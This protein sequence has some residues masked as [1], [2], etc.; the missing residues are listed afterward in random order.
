MTNDHGHPF[1]TIFLF[2][3]VMISTAACANNVASNQIGTGAVAVLDFS[4]LKLK[5][6]PNQYLV[7]PEDFCPNA[8]P[9]RQSSIYAASAPAL[10]EAIIG[11][12]EQEPRTKR[13]EG[14]DDAHAYEYVQRSALIGFPDYISV[15]IIPV[16]GQGATLAIYSRSK[17]G[18]SDLGVNKKRV[19][20]WLDMLDMAVGH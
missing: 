6:S 14:D 8:T 1:L 13:L 16:E 19:T 7:C 18:Y 2:L 11:V 5:P 4:T 9:H 3:L 17:F 15:R 12:I 10:T 20:H